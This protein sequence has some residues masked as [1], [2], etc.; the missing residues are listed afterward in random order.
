MTKV[1]KIA[2]RG[3]P[4]AR[5]QAEH[6]A[7]LLSALPGGPRCEIQVVRT[8]GDD[9]PDLP[10]SSIGAQGVFVREVQ[11]AV[12]DGRANIAVHSAKDL[13]SST[14]A[15]LTI[16]AVP[17]RED[18]RDALVGCRLD[19]LRPGAVVATGS[20][21]R[22][23]QLAWLR[24]DLTF[25]DL[26]GSMETRLDR[27]M[28]VG[29]G[30]VAMAALRRLG[31]EDRVA[32]VLD[33]RVMLPQVGQGALAVECRADDPVVLSLV[34]QIDDD[35]SHTALLAERAFLKGVGGGCS[36]PVAGSAEVGQD[37]LVNIEAMLA[38]RDGHVLLRTGQSGKDPEALGA[39]I[40][41][42]LLDDRGG[43]SLWDWQA[44]GDRPT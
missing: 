43:R 40:A 16:A 24:P 35:A 44:D 36:L 15:D 41:R 22:R 20:A 18:R 31:L 42:E 10:L 30:L 12:L 37:G 39:S 26:R 9:R 5:W 23:A 4:L 1:L 13:P 7:Q 33:T 32:E 6:V 34:A 17:G 27:C 11:H 38:S 29:A 28:S 3:S 25:V 14:P 19:S 8:S 2:T 21:R